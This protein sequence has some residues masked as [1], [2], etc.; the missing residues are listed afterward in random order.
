MIHAISS[1]ILDK[2]RGLPRSEIFY[3]TLLWV[4]F[5]IW[6]V[7]IRF[8]EAEY[9]IFRAKGIYWKVNLNFKDNP[10]YQEI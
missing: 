2:D 5:K 7:V 8:R 1:E 10:D 3:P 6:G 9:R 4:P